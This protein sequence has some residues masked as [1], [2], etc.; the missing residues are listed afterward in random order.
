MIIICL[1]ILLL[2]VLYLREYINQIKLFTSL[3]SFFSLHPFILLISAFLDSIN[4]IENNIN[5]NFDNIFFFI[6]IILYSFFNYLIWIYLNKNIEPSLRIYFSNLKFKKSHI[7][8]LF[9]FAII[10]VI[11]KLLFFN[12]GLTAE[13]SSIISLINL[14]LFY[15]SYTSL[16][17]CLLNKKYK[18]SLI[19]TVLLLI[20][21]FYSSSKGVVLNIIFIYVLTFY[22]KS[23][24]LKT[25]LNPIK[26]FFL[27]SVILGSFLYSN[28]YRYTF[29]TWG[30]FN[31]N[32][33][34]LIE[35]TQALDYDD[36][37]QSQQIN[38]FINR[39]EVYTNFKIQF[40]RNNKKK[41]PYSILSHKSF[42][43][44][45]P[46][47]LYGFIFGEQKTYFSYFCSKELI[48]FT[49]GSSASV[50]KIGEA[51]YNWGLF[52]VFDQLINLFLLIFLIKLII[53][54]NL[55]HLFILMFLI[56]ISRDDAIF[57]NSF[58]F[59]YSI[60]L[61]IIII[62]LFEKINLKI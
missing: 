3:F 55:I 42:F 60:V 53:S 37:D 41:E 45:L 40:N 9:V 35:S 11:Y 23:E 26:L 46:Q 25:L 52:F 28:I 50:G 49:D 56:L 21:F 34:F 24:S 48:G 5:Y 17:L 10:V 2:I 6:I 13:N 47:N 33:D 58:L 8:I 30:D 18:Y 54:Y 1:F 51:Y 38:Y 15:T 32:K 16:F 62:S 27:I 19:L 29:S 31:I 61:E 20:E 57:E 44:F 39:N 12:Y 7:N 59:M 22:F 4:I 36:I 14:L 43:N